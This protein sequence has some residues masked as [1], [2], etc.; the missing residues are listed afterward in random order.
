MPQS[1]F[2]S[3]PSA[4]SSPKIPRSM[5]RSLTEHTVISQVVASRDE[6]KAIELLQVHMAGTAAAYEQ[7]WVRRGRASAKRAPRDKPAAESG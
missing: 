4:I 1:R 6:E 2:A 7:E 3:R 5:Q